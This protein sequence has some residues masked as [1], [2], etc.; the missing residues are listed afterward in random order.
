MFYLSHLTLFFIAFIYFLKFKEM[1]VR[2]TK[3]VR[4][5][6]LENARQ[7]SRALRAARLIPLAL[8]HE[9]NDR[10]VDLVYEVVRLLAE[11]GAD[12]ENRVVVDELEKLAEQLIRPDQAALDPVGEPLLVCLA[13][14]HGLEEALVGE[15]EL[16]AK[17]GRL[18]GAP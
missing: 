16:V 1:E 10:V 9:A 13:L 8:A 12:Q 15:A 7:G 11:R 5:L 14:R 3:L 17:A 6:A 2:F 4:Q 18:G